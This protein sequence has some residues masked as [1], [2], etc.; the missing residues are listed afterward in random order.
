MS[1]TNTW[2]GFRSVLCPIDFSEH[3]RRAL[4]YAVA[5]AQR[6]TAA[7][8]VIY[9]NDPLLIASAAVALHDRQLAEQSA[10]E[11]DEFVN[12]TIPPALREQLRLTSGV[13]SGEAADEI[14]QDAERH[15][16]DLIVIG[17]H[18]LTGAERAFMGSTTLGVLERTT[19]PVLAIPRG[20]GPATPISPAWP[21]QR[22]VA[23]V[24][25][26][27]GDVTTE[28]ETAAQIAQWFGSSLVLA[29]VVTE[30]AAP[31]WLANDLSARDR[32]R[33]AQAEK[34]IA[35]V[36]LVAQRYVQTE[37]RV[38]CGRIAD[39][40]AALAADERTELLIT[41]MHDRRNWFGA[42]R[43]SISF[44]VVLHAVTPVLAYPPEWRPR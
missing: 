11:L 25:V 19:V 34:Q 40:I 33:I 42:K 21:G 10:R 24:D 7:V 37:V 43:G 36:A 28:V 26:D 44:H 15:G 9:V 2:T 29:D 4:Q 38:V 27:G 5:I 23:P 20:E 30:I 16:I 3:A 1:R 39:E 6:G 12:A 22:I 35:G 18:G 8:R 41:A 13:A 14:V 31:A 17:T 32:I